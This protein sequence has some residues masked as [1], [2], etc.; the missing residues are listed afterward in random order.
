MN[1]ARTQCMVA[2]ELLQPIDD[3]LREV[4][5]T[6]DGLTH[7]VVDYGH[8]DQASAVVGIRPEAQDAMRHEFYNS[9]IYN[10]RIDLGATALGYAL[11]QTSP[12]YLLSRMNPKKHMTWAE[13]TIIDDDLTGGLQVA[14]R[15][16]LGPVPSERTMQQLWRHHIDNINEVAY[17]FSRLSKQVD[18]LGDAL[19]LDAP[20]TP[21]AYIIGW[22]LNSSTILA[23]ERYGSL[24][25]YLLDA[26]ELLYRI[27]SIDHRI[28]YDD[29][30]DGQHFVLW[31]PEYVDRANPSSLSEYLESD[32]KPLV[33]RMY[34]AHQLLS[35]DYVDIQPEIRFALGLASVDQDKQ[36]QTTTPELW[37]ITD[38]L[39]DKNNKAL[40]AMT[41]TV[42]NLQRD[43]RG[44]DL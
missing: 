43:N 34:I 20:A 1:E 14:F 35:D 15:H 31:L 33:E 37:E 16:D 8:T 44:V 10:R 25:N 18:S 21:N 7:F 6:Y 2:A 4:S 19:E 9:S 27:A 23:K 11:R 5:D 40:V 36:G 41:S 32:I 30:G 39:G 12:Q 24:R 42:R 29:T 22:D 28:D 13:P 3:D 26:K 17:N 38:T